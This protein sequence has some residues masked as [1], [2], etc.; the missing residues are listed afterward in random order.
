MTSRRSVLVG[1]AALPVASLLVLARCSLD[2]LSDGTALDGGGAA[3]DVHGDDGVSAAADGSKPS[4][5]A[6]AD[7][8][9][10]PCAVHPSDGELYCHNTYGAP[11]YAQPKNASDVV[12]HLD[13]EYS[14]FDCWIT[15]DLHPGGNTTWYRSFGNDDPANPRQGFVRAWD[16]GTSAGF[17]ADPTASGL[18]PC[19]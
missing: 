14:A 2:G 19:M 18:K 7:S 3:A 17:D 12:D 6:D 10:P 15:G 8:R 5:G 4:S 13:S 11:V 1:V 9:F 16:L